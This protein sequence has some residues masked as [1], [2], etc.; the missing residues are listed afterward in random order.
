MPSE[1]SNLLQEKHAATVA[2]APPGPPVHV[3]D[4]LAEFLGTFLL[5]GFGLGVNNQVA[6]NGGD[7][8]DWL[9]VNVGWGIGLFLGASA[10]VGV[11]GGHLNPAV[12]LTMAWFGHLPWNKVPGYILAQTV[13]AFVA[14]IVVCI[15]YYPLYDIK[16]PT[17]TIAQAYYATYPAEHIGNLNA[18]VTEFFGTA[19]LLLGILAI[20]DAKNAPASP[21]ST[22]V[23][24]MLLLTGLGICFGSNTGYA[25]NP[26]RDFGPRLM[27]ACFGWGVRVF[28]IADGYFWIPIVA[29]CLGGIAGGYFYRFCVSNLHPTDGCNV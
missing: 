26:A 25:L 24:L 6:L 7:R 21:S 15:L 14:A 20:T 23:Q 18:F 16:D 2:V 13:A 27:T 29:P 9:S 3:R 11:S 1:H 8:G 10:A 19:M 28:T 22:P 12:T 17:R 4:C 5:V